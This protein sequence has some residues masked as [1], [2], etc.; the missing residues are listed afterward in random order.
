MKKLLL[1]RH[2]LPE[3]SSESGEDI[4]RELSEQGHAQAKTLGKTMRDNNNVPD[5]VLC[6][7]AMRTRKTLEGLGFDN[8]R[9]EFLND[10]YL[11]SA[12]NILDAIHDIIDDTNET[13]LIVTHYPGVLE[14]AYKM[15]G[16][17]TKFTRGYPECAL[18]IFDCDVTSWSDLRPQNARMD[19]F[20]TTKR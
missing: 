14:F 18:T 10:L 19:S 15:S 12:R 2:A 8:V 7:D 13:I 11:P 5:F 3:Q 6:S 9:T 17:I 1:L 4:D 20:L 16:A